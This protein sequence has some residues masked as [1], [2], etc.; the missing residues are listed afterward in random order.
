MCPCIDAIPHQCRSAPGQGGF[1]RFDMTRES[2]WSLWAKKKTEQ[3]KT[4][5]S[6]IHYTNDWLCVYGVS[7][8]LE[9]KEKPHL[10]QL[11]DCGGKK[12]KKQRSAANILGLIWLCLK[13]VLR[14]FSPAHES[15]CEINRTWENKFNYLEV[16][17][18]VNKRLVTPMS[19]QTDF[20]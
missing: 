13:V 6:K 4:N 15:N 2:L 8:F 19:K 16:L 11:I 18:C 17:S 14:F 3:K 9:A 12:G 10:C 5:P 20:I 1:Q 7:I